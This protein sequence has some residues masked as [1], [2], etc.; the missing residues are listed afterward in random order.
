MITRPSPTRSGSY[1]KGGDLVRSMSPSRKIAI[2]A[3]LLCLAFPEV[4]L[5][6]DPPDTQINPQPGRSEAVDSA[7]IGGNYEV[8]HAVKEQGGPPQT[9]TLTSSS[10]DDNGPRLIIAPNGDTTVVW[11]RDDT[12]DAV[13]T[14]TLTYSTGLWSSEER[15][16]LTTQSA[17]HPE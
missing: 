9:T 4:G 10:L 1:S 15:V 16:S 5:A 6:S 8:R 17:S 2:A 13:Y 14:R 11:W 12:T 7:L 3:S